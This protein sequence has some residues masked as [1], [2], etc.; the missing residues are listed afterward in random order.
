MRLL[1]IILLLIFMCCYTFADE[2]FLAS[3]KKLINVNILENEETNESITVWTS[4][5]KK[6]KIPKDQI[7]GFILSKYNPQKKSEEINHGNIFP[8]QMIKFSKTARVT[9]SDSTISL[10]INRPEI[11]DRQS[12][13]M[14]TESIEDSL[15][16]NFTR[17]RASL[18]FGISRRFGDIPDD[19]EPEVVE[20]LKDL[21]V[22][23]DR[24]FSFT[25]Y[26]WYDKGISVLFHNFTSSFSSGNFPIVIDDGITVRGDIDN[27][28]TI[29]FIGFGYSQRSFF[30]EHDLFLTMDLSFGIMNFT[31]KSD[32]SFNDSGLQGVGTLEI[33]GSA[34]GGI[35]TVGI[36]K[37]LTNNVGLGAAVTLTGGELDN[38]EVNGQKFD[39][40]EPENLGKVS[41][42][43][44]IRFYF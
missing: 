12:L 40:D 36:E 4:D 34:P 21:R 29:S 42:N 15:Y 35:W 37:L 43:F 6:R 25:Y 28:I 33:T 19:V 16:D 38:V 44:G 1:Q 3:G 23:F 9:A 22:G 8:D 26:H 27:D 11:T 39:L 20:A 32:I 13:N 24:E 31:D 41:M 5:R 7:I 2:I 14:E 10:N 30:Y 18:N 17:T